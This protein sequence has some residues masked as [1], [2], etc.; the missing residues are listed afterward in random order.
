MFRKR[1]QRTRTFLK[2]RR[3][4]KTFKKRMTSANWNRKYSLANI[5]R[6]YRQVMKLEKKVKGRLPTKGEKRKLAGVAENNFEELYRKFSGRAP[7]PPPDADGGHLWQ[8]NHGSLVLDD[9]DAPYIDPISHKPYYHMNTWWDYVYPHSTFG[10][11]MGDE[12]TYEPNRVFPNTLQNTP[13]VGIGSKWS[14]H[15]SNRMQVLQ[16]YHPQT[17]TDGPGLE[18]DSATVETWLDPFKDRVCYYG[19]NEK[20]IDIL[21]RIYHFKQLQ[22]AR[23]VTPPEE[24]DDVLAMDLQEDP[25]VEGQGDLQK[26][27]GCLPSRLTDKVKINNFWL[28]FDFDTKFAGDEGTRTNV[29]VTDVT[30]L[31]QVAEA[32]QGYNNFRTHVE[33]D[34]RI[35]NSYAKVRIIIGTRK[36]FGRVAQDR[37]SLNHILKSPHTAD[38]QHG[39]TNEEVLNDLF[40]RQN[41]RRGSMQGVT[42]QNIEA[43]EYADIK[44]EKDEIVTLGKGHSTKHFNLFKNHV[45][46]YINT[47]DDK[48]QVPDH[49]TMLNPNVVDTKQELY[50][51]FG[52]VALHDIDVTNQ[53]PGPQRFYVPLENDMFMYVITLTRGAAVRWRLSSK[54]TYVSI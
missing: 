43:D 32:N 20:K 4:L 13:Y 1:V 48:N 28:K 8:G 26:W 40:N 17:S 27:A 30:A 18:G 19:Y 49:Y 52:Q 44:I 16:D 35:A 54:L 47:D 51:N 12:D 33:Y 53:L 2:R 7:F 23:R 31:D 42:H 15:D 5:Q 34:N 3:A 37:V 38:M 41:L 9:T 11:L 24:V 10:Q 46:P 36:K 22:T 21:P 45:I 29:F 14:P 6:V 25:Y 50:D 39:F